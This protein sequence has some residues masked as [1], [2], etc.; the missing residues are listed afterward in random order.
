MNDLGFTELERASI[1]G[2]P[3]PWLERRNSVTLI[4]TIAALL[5]TASALSRSFLDGRLA[6]PMT[7]DDVN[8]FIEGIQRLTILRTQGFFAL[9]SDF[10]H[11]FLHAPLLTYQAMLAYLIFGIEDWAPYVT[12]VVYVVIFFGFAA[13]L[14]RDCAAIVL[15]SVMA[16]LISMSIASNR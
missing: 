7:H 4:V 2:Q 10:F 15:A 1:A 12:N 8:Y 5:V 9:V 3:V 16:C 14:V 13:W 11:G 6:A